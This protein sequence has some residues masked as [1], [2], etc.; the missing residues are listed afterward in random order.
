MDETLLTRTGPKTAADYKSAFAELLREITK[1]EEKMQTNR[2]EI[3]RLKVETQ[4]LKAET[5]IIKVRSQERIDA[6]SALV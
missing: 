1:I 2:A 3:E 6:L 4:I 5:D